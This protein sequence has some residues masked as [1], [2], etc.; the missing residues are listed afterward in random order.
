MVGV[1]STSSRAHQ[2]AAGARKAKP[3]VPKKGRRLGTRD[4]VDPITDEA[5]LALLT[6]LKRE[7]RDIAQAA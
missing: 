7:V 4:I 5:A 1:D 3:R 6:R 2:H